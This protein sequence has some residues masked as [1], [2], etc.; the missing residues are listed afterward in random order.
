M[1]GPNTLPASTT[2]RRCARPQGQASPGSYLVWKRLQV[3][4]EGI[5]TAAQYEIVRELGCALGQGLYLH[6]PLSALEAA[7]LLQAGRRYAA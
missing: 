3:V 6:A 2:D 4:A 7:R 5:E 1:P